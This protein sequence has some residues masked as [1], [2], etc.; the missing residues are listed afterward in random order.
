M[1]GCLLRPCAILF[2]SA[3]AAPCAA[4]GLGDPVSVRAVA[5]RDRVWPGAQ[6]AV[7]VVVDLDEGW[8]IWPAAEQNALAPEIASFAIPTKLVIGTLGSGQEAREPAVTKGVL[9]PAIRIAGPPI[10]PAPADVKNPLDGGATNTKGFKGRAIV[11][12]PVVLNTTASPGMVSLPLHVYY[13]ACDAGSCL[14]PAT[15]TVRV[16]L[17]VI[18]MD[19]PLDATPPGG[20]AAL[21]QAFD[22]TVFEGLLAGGSSSARITFEFFG[23]SFTLDPNSAWGIVLLL[24]VAALGGLL[25]N[26]TPCVLPVIPLKVLS[27]GHAAA[28]SRARYFYLGIVMSLG[29]V[30]FFVALGAAVAYLEGFD[31]ISSLFQRTWFGISMGALIGVMGFGM[32]GRFSTGLPQWVYQLDPQKESTL[33]SYLWGILTAVLSTP[34]TA[35]FMGA[36]VAWATQQRPHTVLVTFGAI[37]A[38]MALPYVVL[39]LNPKWVKFVPKSG[40]ASEVLKQVMGLVLLGVASFF[41]G[42]SVAP[43]LRESPGDPVPRGHWYV[44]ALF[45]AAAAA[46]TAIRCYRITTSPAKR[47]LWTVLA[48]AVIAASARLAYTQTDKGPIAWIYYTP[49]RFAAAIARGEVVVLDFTAEWCLNC[50]A[51]EAAVLHQPAVTAVLN[52]DGV[53]PIKVDITG[54]NPDGTAKLNE[55]GWKGIPLLAIYGPGLATPE[56]F[57]AYNAERVLSTIERAR[58]GT[59][60]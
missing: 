26:L 4:Q 47:A 28:G 3:F 42:T 44:V 40:P 49:E 41:V 7:A 14:M 24:L 38:G 31:S 46:W 59:G 13:Q 33:G 10:W 8:K 36:A 34:C 22:P 35:P 58:R 30:T 48:I 32:L 29:V 57:D 18:P 6:L 37:G 25:L 52:S 2:A 39:A 27:L 1:P 43:L 5:Q 11:Y 56:K 51:I 54:G 50:K 21:F 45:V 12:V 9:D 20:E 19:T 53:T 55:L 16:T 15:R 17:D 60:G 23:A